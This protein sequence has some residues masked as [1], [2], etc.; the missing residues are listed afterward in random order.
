M[1][2]PTNVGIGGFPSLCD[3]CYNYQMFSAPEKNI[4]QLGLAEN[5]LVADFGCGPG[6]YTIAAAKALNGTGKVY[7]I[8]V[9]KDLL[10]KLEGTCHDQHIGNVSFIWGNL[11]LPGG[12]KLRDGSCDVVILSNLLFQ[13]PNKEGVI[14]EVRRVL[15]QGGRLLLI[16]WTASFNNMGPTAGQVYPENEARNLVESK[17]FTFEKAISAGNFHYGL[18]FRKGLYQGRD[19]PGI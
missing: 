7:A 19:T 15:R 3:K 9:Q 5:L 14:D 2:P 16:D 8:E 17:S 12:T 18:I 4:E 1:I 6:A 11:E 10:T 13:A